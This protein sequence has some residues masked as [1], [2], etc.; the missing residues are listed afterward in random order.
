MIR[1]ETVNNVSP[2][3]PPPLLHYLFSLLYLLSTPPPPT[4]TRTAVC[5][6]AVVHVVCSGIKKIGT[7]NGFFLR[8]NLLRGIIQHSSVYL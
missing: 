6:Q 2:A 1:F 8:G 3:P 5:V 7:K 4:V